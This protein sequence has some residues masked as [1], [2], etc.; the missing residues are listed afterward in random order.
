MCPLLCS[1]TAVCHLHLLA[2]VNPRSLTPW[3]GGLCPVKSLA[4]QPWGA[5]SPIATKWWVWLPFFSLSFNTAFGKKK[6]PSHTY[7]TQDSQDTARQKATETAMPD[8][9]P[10]SRFLFLLQHPEDLPGPYPGAVGVQRADGGVLRRA[11]LPGGY[12]PSPARPPPPSGPQEAAQHRA[13]P[14]AFTSWLCP[15]LAA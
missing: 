15:L 8:L 2:G 10:P 7:L 1:D 12:V 6:L 3:S 11:V 13:G 14:S 4:T 9:T 5:R